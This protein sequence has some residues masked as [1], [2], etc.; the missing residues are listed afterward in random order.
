[1]VSPFICLFIQ[2][3]FI[4]GLLCARHSESRN[5]TDLIPAFGNWFVLDLDPL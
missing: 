5:K 3:T 1:M 2:Q 4:V